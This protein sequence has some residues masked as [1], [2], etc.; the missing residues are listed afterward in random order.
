MFRALLSP[1][2]G[3]RVY[4]CVV[5]AYGVQ[6]LVTGCQGSEA[7]QQSMS[8]GRGMLHDPGL[9]GLLPAPDQPT[10]SNQALHTIGGNNTYIVS[11]SWWWAQKC[12][13]HVERIISAINHSVASSGFFFSAHMQ[14]CTDRQTSSKNDL[15]ICVIKYATQI[16]KLYIAALMYYDCE[17]IK[18]KKSAV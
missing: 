2:S 7:E 14:R 18:R 15:F 5:T 17:V 12:P 10:T 11:S 1:S 16:V 8:S 9:P 13:K 6:C 3:A 4:M